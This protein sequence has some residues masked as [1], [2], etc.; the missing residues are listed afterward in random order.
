MTTSTVMRT[1]QKKRIFKRQEH[2]TDTRAKTVEL[3]DEGKTIIKKAIIAVETFDAHFF[4]Q[5]GNRTQ[6]FNKIL[7]GLLQQKK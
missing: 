1:L 3:T 6:D 2:L 5:L 7:L 4:S